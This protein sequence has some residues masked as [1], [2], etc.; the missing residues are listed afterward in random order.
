[1]PNVDR[2]LAFVLVAT[3]HGSMILNWLDYH[4]LDATRVYGVGIELFQSGRFSPA[5]SASRSACWICP[6][7]TLATALSQSTAP[8]ILASTRWDGP[9]A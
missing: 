9:S 3:G 8:P 1:M 4:V 6:A 5:E 7:A 2:K